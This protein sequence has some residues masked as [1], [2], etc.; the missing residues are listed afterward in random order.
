MAAAVLLLVVFGGGAADGF[1]LQHVEMVRE[2]NTAPAEA[3]SH[4]DAGLWAKARAALERASGRLG[5][6]GPAKLRQQL[7]LAT[8]N[9][10][11][12]RRFNSTG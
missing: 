4:R 6:R 2:S 12:V 5:N 11:L 3:A 10:D 1:R 7:A 9:L 8:S